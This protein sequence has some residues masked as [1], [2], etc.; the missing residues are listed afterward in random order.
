MNT[1]IGISVVQNSCIQIPLITF[2]NKDR[3]Y[4]IAGVHDDV[5]SVSYC[6]GPKLS[7]TLDPEQA[8]DH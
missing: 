5:L 3:C 7:T 1:V 8:D 6:T 4:R 2:R